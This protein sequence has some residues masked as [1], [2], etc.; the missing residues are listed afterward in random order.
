MDKR[1]TTFIIAAAA[2]LTAC[3]TDSIYDF[4]DNE[5]DGNGQT[6]GTGDAASLGDLATFDVATDT[7]ALT[8]TDDVDTSNSDYIE[9]NKFTR[10]VSIT[11]NGTSASVGGSVA[12]VSVTCNGADVVVRSTAKKVKYT[13][14]GTTANGS[15]KIYSNNKF[16]MELS[17]AS[18]TNPAG[19]AINIQTG[20]RCYLV[21]AD[22][23]TNTLTDGTS[24]AEPDN[25][26]SAK[27]TL[28]SEG[29]LLFSG[30]GKLRVYANCKAGIRS[31]DYIL[32]RPGNNI[33]VKATAGNGIKAN[34]G[35]Y[36]RGGAINV[37]ASAPAA[38][39]I[40]SGAFIDITGGRTISTTTGNAQPDES[41]DDASS[42]AALSADSTL[43]I[44]GGQLLCKSTGT[45]GKG[46]NAK[47]RLDIA[48]GTVR[49]VT[50]GAKY[51]EGSIT[52]SPKGIKANGS[53]TVS[54]GDIMVR[55]S[56]GDGAAGMESKASLTLTGG[57][58]RHYSH[59]DALKADSTITAKGGTVFAYST[60]GDGITAG[61]AFT[62][63]GTTVIA[64]GATSPHCG[65]KCPS[66]AL[67]ANGGTLLGIGGGTAVPSAT[68]SSQPSAIIGRCT[69]AC[70]STIAMASDNG[71]SM[72]A[73]V[74]P[75]RYTNCNVLFSS[76]S[77][78]TGTTCRLLSGV[79][80]NGGTPF[81]GF[82]TDAA[83]S[84]GNE[85]ASVEITS[86][87]NTVRFDGKT[88]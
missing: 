25:G 74:L 24:Y 79:T 46:I 14:A 55:A 63:C 29:E 83:T 28:F 21:V 18:I 13:V 5:T 75:R 86:K 26:E 38:K 33:F 41:G 27:A 47:Q 73:F 32:F 81:C 43:S 69:F 8:E 48:G 61:T 22:G 10:H 42:A 49:V 66:N 1:I 68:A 37:E 85:E 30:S 52:A 65:I 77:L 20:K 36:I 88:E 7:T 80:A 2:S 23:T 39:G 16:A 82:Y 71:K 51:A 40:T 84:G 9:N 76:P 19:P 78:T 64:C 67:L 70:G 6:F 12:G 34:D 4:I 35:I 59:D 54:G 11:F 44:S 50:T 57:T 3:Q 15:L 60:H 87:L 31:D 17:G 53:I 56:G 62:M 45:G 72:F 58:M